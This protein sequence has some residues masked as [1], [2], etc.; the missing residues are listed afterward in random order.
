MKPKAR[1]DAPRPG[2]EAK[3]EIPSCLPPRKQNGSST[4][5]GWGHPRTFNKQNCY[6]LP[7]VPVLCHGHIVTRRL[8]SRRGSVGLRG[9]TGAGGRHSYRPRARARSLEVPARLPERPQTCPPSVHLV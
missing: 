9:D 4:L 5:I 8:A 1:R 3:R 7:L 6:F 2:K